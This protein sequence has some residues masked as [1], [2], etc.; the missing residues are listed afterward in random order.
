MKT[1]Y[2]IGFMGAG[3]TTIGKDLAKQ[4]NLSVF[5]TDEEIV[6]RTGMSIPSIFS[7]KG[8]KTFRDLETDI[9]TKLPVDDNIVTTG[10]GIVLKEENRSWMKETGHVIFLDVSPQEVLRRLSEDS[11]RPLL[12][13]EKEKSVYNLLNQ[14][15]P[16]YQSTAH[17]QI[18]TDGKSPKEIILELENCLK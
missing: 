13:S 17:F 2:L 3:K 11:S 8:E 12:N 16:L 9:L 4:W 1:I 18:Q 15:L 10:G 7:T 14:R 5:D 6:K